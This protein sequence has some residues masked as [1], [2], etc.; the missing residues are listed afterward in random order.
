LTIEDQIQTILS[1]DFQPIKFEIKNNSYLHK[2]HKEYRENSHYSIIIVS[3]SF[4]KKN[5]VERHQMI[6]KSL[7]ELMKTTIHALQIKA[8]SISEYN[9]I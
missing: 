5:K 3:K 9:K 4:D 8:Y 7:K 1:K 2:N 6:Y